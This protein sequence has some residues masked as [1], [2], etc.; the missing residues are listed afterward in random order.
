MDPEAGAQ[1]AAEKAIASAG[2]FA[3]AE[4]KQLMARK[5]A[6]LYIENDSERKKAME[7]LGKARHMLGMKK[8]A[9]RPN[10]YLSGCVERVKAVIKASEAQGDNLDLDKYADEAEGRITGKEPFSK[11]MKNG[12]NP[13][14]FNNPKQKEEVKPVPE[15]VAAPE[16][17]KPP[18]PTP[19]EA[20][21]EK[22]PEQ[23]M[24]APPL[25]KTEDGLIE[26]PIDGLKL[27]V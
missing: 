16:E 14:L 13:F 11:D 4:T 20:P 9:S 27:K 7:M 12:Y 15:P 22:E 1:K 6:A 2:K 23:P 17:P 8:D 21:V 25:K 24:L 18:A 10:R 3:D 5:A 26:V 19:V